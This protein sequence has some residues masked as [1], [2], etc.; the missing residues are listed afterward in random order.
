MKSHVEFKAIKMS[1]YFASRALIDDAN[2]R[3]YIK[4]NR[5]QLVRWLRLP[6]HVKV[7]SVLSKFQLQQSIL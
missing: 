2:I 3:N 6:L 7:R 4:G 1:D 5:A